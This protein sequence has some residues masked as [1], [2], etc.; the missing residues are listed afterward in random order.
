MTVKLVIVLATIGILLILESKFPFF[1]FPN[2]LRSRITNNF[3]LGA[4]NSLLSSLF[5]VAVSSSKLLSSGHS[6]LFTQIS[7]PAIAGGLAFVV[8]D[9]YMYLWHRSM[10][11]IPLAWRFHQLHHTD[12]TM[13]VSTAYRFHPIEII[14]SSIPKLALIWWLAIPSNFVLIYELVFTVVVAL[15]HSNLNL[16]AS[17]DRILSSI[18][19]TPNYHRIHHSQIVS[20][21]NSNYSSVLIWWDR[22]FGTHKSRLD[23]GDIQ[24]GIADETRELNIWQF[25]GFRL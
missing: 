20:E 5:A 6:G 13:N 24:L 7:E 21:T 23:I 9:L 1:K 14:S 11:V 2:S 10:H 18:I 4:I 19:L 25:L 12:R 3:E 15:H 16:P 8:L 17:L 22:L